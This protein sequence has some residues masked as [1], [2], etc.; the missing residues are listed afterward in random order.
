MARRNAYTKVVRRTR[1]QADHVKGMG[2]VAFKGFQCLNVQCQNFLFV[3]NDAIGATFEIVCPHCQYIM[4][5]GDTTALFDFD[6]LDLRDDSVLETGQFVILHDD[7]IAE[8]EEYKYCILCSTMKPLTYF[9]KHA[10]RATKRQGECRLCKGVY[11]SI[12]NRTRL[13]EQHREAAQKRRL[14]L[15]LSGGAHIKEK[16]IYERFNYR[17]FKCGKDLRNVQDQRERPL[18][19]TLPARY[20]WPL[21]TENATLLCQQHNGEKSDK[22]PA[23]YYTL[24]EQKR[25]SV[26]TGLNFDLL[27]GPP[28]YN[29]DALSQL[30][31]TEHIDDLLTRYA[32]YMPEI[33]KL[34]N[35]LLHETKID[36]FQNSALISQTWVERADEEFRRA[37]RSSISVNPT[38]DTDAM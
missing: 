16:D 35:R 27:H 6:L 13:T 12:K 4:R 7:Y 15:D 18:D 10:S 21:T 5:S 1:L 22:W 23:E 20:L 30:Q 19:H 3:R 26:I 25:L 28:Q 34:R 33:I 2:D 36:M 24:D 38:P 11:N 8:A 32:A 37:V 9:D 17:C 29:P 31:Q 14:Y